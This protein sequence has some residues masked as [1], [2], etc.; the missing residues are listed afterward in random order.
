MRA[1]SRH[2]DFCYESPT[3][4]NRGPAQR[5]ILGFFLPFLLGFPIA[6]SLVF[7][8]FFGFPFSYSFLTFSLVF[9][10]ICSFII[11]DAFFGFHRG[12]L[13]L[14][15]FFIFNSCLTFYT[16]CTPSSIHKGHFLTYIYN[17]F[18]YMVNIILYRF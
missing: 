13:D 6:C 7:L 11:S 14:F 16:W 1:I 5:C 3:D 9:C 4:G 18:K 12:I 15:S 8:H 2:T 17:I 10:F